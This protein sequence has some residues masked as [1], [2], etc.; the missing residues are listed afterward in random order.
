MSN[1]GT[2]LPRTRGGKG[3]KH[4]VGAFGWFEF[5]ENFQTLKNIYALLKNEQ[6]IISFHR[7]LVLHWRIEF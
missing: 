4:F 1:L 6:K 2:E 5:E 7:K 3:I